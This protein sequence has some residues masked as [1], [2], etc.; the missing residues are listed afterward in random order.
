M[1]RWRSEAITI[2]E[3]NHRLMKQLRQANNNKGDGN[4]QGDDDDKGDDDEGDNEGVAVG[5]KDEERDEKDALEHYTL[6]RRQLEAIAAMQMI[7]KESVRLQQQ[8]HSTNKEKSQFGKERDALL[9]QEKANRAALQRQLGEINSR[10]DKQRTTVADLASTATAE[11]SK[12]KKEHPQEHH[13]NH[14]DGEQSKAHQSAVRML[15]N[16]EEH[17]EELEDRLEQ[18]RALSEDASLRLQ[19]L[20]DELETLE[21]EMKVTTARLKTERERIQSLRLEVIRDG[22]D[23]DGGDGDDEY[24]G[25]SFDMEEGEE[26]DEKEDEKVQDKDKVKDMGNKDKGSDKD[27]ANENKRKSSRDNEPSSSKM[28]R[29][30][31]EMVTRAISNVT[32]TITDPTVTRARTGTRKHSASRGSFNVNILVVT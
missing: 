1:E 20:T 4:D 10:I 23:E 12:K 6:L 25:E 16:Y 22:G 13:H 17:R 31:R 14:H 7:Q 18:P 8:L 2:R 9:D 19:E 30:M 27:K 24:A 5:V 11:E 3:E 32:T 28:R 26:E 21:T 15:R 29:Q